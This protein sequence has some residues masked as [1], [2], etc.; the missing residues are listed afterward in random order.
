[1][2]EYVKQRIR[3]EAN[4]MLET[5]KTVRQIA[6]KYGYSKSTVHKDLHERLISLDKEVYENVAQIMNCHA[7]D[8]HIK[9]GNSTR[10][11]Y[12]LK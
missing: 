4:E 7:N 12:K 10:L 8:K 3:K 11:K 9:G 1:M 2:K 5:G 6:I